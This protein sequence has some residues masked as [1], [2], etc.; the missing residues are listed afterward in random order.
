MNSPSGMALLRR[1]L[2]YGWLFRD[3]SVGTYW[4]RAA[5]VAHN[6][7]QAR[8]LPTY[9]VRWL[10]IAALLLAIARFCEIALASPALSAPFYLLSTMTI[11]FNA[12]TVA[13]WALLHSGW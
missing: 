9:F 12:V 8:W 1:Y 6:R 11:A 13:C 5:A 7:R 4:E 10:A 2:F 3:A